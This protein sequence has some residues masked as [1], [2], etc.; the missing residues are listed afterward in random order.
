[1][2]YD[3]RGPESFLDLDAKTPAGNDANVEVWAW[4]D[5]PVCVAVEQWLPAWGEKI[6]V[7]LTAAQVRALAKALNA[8]ADHAEHGDDHSETITTGS[9]P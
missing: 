2:T 9:T 3:A 6:E 4:S 5:G 8:A 1:M 7:N